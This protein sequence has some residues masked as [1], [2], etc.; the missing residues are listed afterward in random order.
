MAC[1]KNGA[2]TKNHGGLELSNLRSNIGKGGGP[3]S[4]RFGKGGATTISTTTISI[5]TR[6]ITRKIEQS[7]K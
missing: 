7:V 3:R 2:L 6:S 1:Q 5:T 4:D